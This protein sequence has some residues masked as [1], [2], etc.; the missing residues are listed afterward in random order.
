MTK[1]NKCPNCGHKPDGGL[2]GGTWFRVYE[3][4]KC[5][6]CY[7]FSCGDTRCPEC[8]SKDRE[9]AGECR[10]K[11]GAEP[12]MSSRSDLDQEADL[13]LT[14][15]DIIK[16]DSK[17]ISLASRDGR[18]PVTRNI[19]VK[20]PKDIRGGKILRLRGQGKTIG[21]STG[22]LFLKIR[23]APEEGVVVNGDDIDVKV[24][25]TPWDAAL[26]TKISAALPDGEVKIKLPPGT[27]SGKRLRLKGKGM[28]LPEGGR[29]DLYAV[30]SIELPKKLSARILELFRVIKN[31]P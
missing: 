19:N 30:I 9:E 2:A 14:L 22:D 29:G 10:K 16:G 3:C 31:T 8:G 1:F 23:I 17:M 20:F 21:A 7:C 24:P 4:G 28:P 15:E 25:V 11:D 13:Q 27:S 18:K 6:T 5:K 26:G 12:L